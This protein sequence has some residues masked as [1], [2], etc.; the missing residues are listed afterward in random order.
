M[1][2]LK[3]LMTKKQE[4]EIR[5]FNKSL[6]EELRGGGGWGG[7]QWSLNRAEGRSIGEDS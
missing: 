2:C 7:V 6:Q 3:G 4:G 5:K 1:S